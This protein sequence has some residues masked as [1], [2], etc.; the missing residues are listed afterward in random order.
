LPI[1][2]LKQ[3]D[4]EPDTRLWTR[5]GSFLPIHQSTVYVVAP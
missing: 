3:F 4:G 1:V 5:W 2:E